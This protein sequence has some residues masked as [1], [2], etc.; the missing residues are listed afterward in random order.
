MKQMLL[1]ILTAVCFHA[2]SQPTITNSYFPVSGDTLRSGVITQPDASFNALITAPGGPFTWDLSSA[3]YDNLVETVYQSAN[4]GTN[5]ANF[6]G[7]DLVVA[8]A[9]GETYFNSTTTA[10]Q[11]MGYAGADP[12]GFGLEVVAKFNPLVTERKAPLNFFDIVGSTTDLSLPFSTDQLPDSLFSG[13]P[14]SPDSIRVRV[15]TDRLDVVNGYG[16]VLLPGATSYDVLRLKRTEYTTTNLDVHIGFLG[17]VD[18]SS[19]LGGGGGGGIGNFI[20][21]DTTVT[22]RFYANDVKEEVAVL[23]LDNSESEVQTVRFKADQ[24]VSATEPEPDFDAPGSPSVAAFPN[25][26]IEWVRFDYQNLPEDD[27]RLRIF[28]LIGNPV[29]DEQ[30]HLSGSKFI[31]LDLDKFKK[32]TYLYSLANKKG[33]VIGTKRLV[34]L[35]P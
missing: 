12:G 5:V 27:Y 10:F 28:T 31:R 30:Y 35:K 3:T 8:G 19:F 9:Q 20:G 34:I 18:V 33:D 14:I 16:K 21:T 13:L 26:A 24:Q 29:W 15:N 17:W 25:P 32:G 7:S 2:S 6:P 22:H 4:T 23:T 1:A 11:A